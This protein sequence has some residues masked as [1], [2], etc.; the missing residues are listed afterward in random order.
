MKT[1]ITDVARLANVSMKTVSRVLN[2]EPNVAKK[3]RERVLSA[4]KELR[5]SPNLA[6]KG[7][8]SSKSYLIAL[9]YDNPS[10]NYI[11]NIQKGAIKACRDN[12]YYLVI[13]PL[14]MANANAGNEVEKLL[15]RLPVDGVI[16]TPPLCDDK[17]VLSILK[18]LNIP[19]V[20]VAPTIEMNGVS[21]VKMDDV[22]ASFE[23]TEYLIRRGHK[24]IGFIKG[25]RGHSA[26]AL[27]YKGY[28]L[29]MEK[30][31]LKIDK[32]FI[33]EGDFS[34]KSG[35]EAAENLLGLNE[36]PTAIFASN[37]DMAA[38]VVSVA[39]RLGLEV[40]TKLSVGGFDDTPL[41][42]ILFPQLTTVKQ[43]IYEMG[44]MA[45]NLLINPPAKDDVL[46]SYHLDHKLIIRES[47]DNQNILDN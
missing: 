32:N 8:A 3:T 14:S 39:S 16:L 13:E 24:K 43:P 47:T 42:Q 22:Q 36:P 33:V 35:V 29:A 9:L 18:S 27:R 7:L 28:E 34:F 30:F 5:Y 6:A 38:G 12:N 26:T 19:Y 11:A 17:D 25:H 21:S 20:P 10:P 31:N 15:E 40:P 4:A 46:P 44:Q 45:A 37:D 23:M 1:T 2:N 41:A